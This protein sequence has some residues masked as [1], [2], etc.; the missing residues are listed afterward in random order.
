MVFITGTEP[1]ACAVQNKSFN[2]QIHE[3]FLHARFV[4]DKT[5]LAQVSSRFLPFT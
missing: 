4:V 3:V 1:V 5:A 2:V